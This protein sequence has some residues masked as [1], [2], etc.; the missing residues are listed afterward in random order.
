MAVLIVIQPRKMIPIEYIGPVP[1]KK[2]KK[3]VMGGWVIMLLAGIFVSYFAWPAFAD[4]VKSSNDM[5]TDN[6]VE[7]AMSELS[8]SGKYS[9]RLA[10]AALDR[11]TSR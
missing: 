5:P 8:S 9:D 6:K 10:A 7:I 11:N 3:P 4:L 1:Q 2:R